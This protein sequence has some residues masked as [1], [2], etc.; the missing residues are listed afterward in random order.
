MCEAW[1]FSWD[2]HLSSLE[3]KYLKNVDEFSQ[4]VYLNSNLIICSFEYE[5][6]AAIIFA[7]FFDM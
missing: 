6:L 2:F 1:F 7:L 4:H 5:L 3:D